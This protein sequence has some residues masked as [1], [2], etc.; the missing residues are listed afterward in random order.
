MIEPAIGKI[1]LITNNY[2]SQYMGKGIPEAIIEEAQ[3]ILDIT[4]VSSSNNPL[5]HTSAEEYRSAPADKM[6]KR[7]VSLRKAIYVFETDSFQFVPMLNT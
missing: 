1:T 4:I 3:K 7:L 6:W 5:F 2:A